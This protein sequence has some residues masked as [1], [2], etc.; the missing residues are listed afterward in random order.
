MHIMVSWWKGEESE[1]TLLRAAGNKLIEEAK[2]LSTQKEE[3]F[4]E[5]LR[6]RGSITIYLVDADDPRPALGDRLLRLFT[7]RQARVLS[8]GKYGA[9]LFL[10][11]S[12]GLGPWTDDNRNH[13]H[14][15]G[16]EFFIRTLSAYS[17]G[18]VIPVPGGDLG[19]S[20]PVARLHRLV[21]GNRE[22]L[23]VAVTLD[24]IAEGIRRLQEVAG[25]ELPRHATHLGAA[26]AELRT[27]IDDARAFTRTLMC[28]HQLGR[29]PQLHAEEAVR[30]EVRWLRG[31][32]GSYELRRCINSLLETAPGGRVTVGGHEWTAEDLGLLQAMLR[33]YEIFRDLAR[34]LASGAFHWAKGLRRLQE[35]KPL[36]VLVIDEI[37]A[38]DRNETDD[39]IARPL[40][41]ALRKK[42]QTIRDAFDGDVTFEYVVHP[43]WSKLQESLAQ[44]IPG[45]ILALG[46]DVEYMP[47]ADDGDRDALAL[48]AAGQ[49]GSE[50]EDKPVPPRLHD[51]HVIL[52]E[53]EYREEYIGPR[54]VRAL[55]SYFDRLDSAHEE[56]PFPKVKTKPRRPPPSI[57]VLTQSVNAD[58]VQKCLNAGA[59]AFV[60]KERILE[61]PTRAT[62]ARILHQESEPRGSR[63]NFRS[64]YQLSHEDRATLQSGASDHLIRGR[65]VDVID[66][67][68]LR[69][70]PKADLHTHIG[71]SIALHTLQALAL[72]TCGH[73]WARRRDN[74]ELGPMLE[75]LTRHLWAIVLLAGWNFR[76]PLDARESVRIRAAVRCMWN[77]SLRIARS[78]APGESGWTYEV[79]VGSEPVDDVFD[80]ILD[81]V[82]KAYPQFTRYEVTSLFVSILTLCE[83]HAGGL[84]GTWPQELW[85]YL[86]LVPDV[87]GRAPSDAPAWPLLD[88]RVKRAESYLRRFAVEGAAAYPPLEERDGTSA[89]PLWMLTYQQVRARIDKVRDVIALQK[90]ATWEQLHAS[91]VRA[92][93]SLIPDATPDAQEAL[94]K[95][96]V[97]SLATLV[98]IPPVPALGERTLKRYLWGTGLLGADH[99]QYPEN[100][101]LA[102]HALVEQAAEENILY[103]ELRCET[104]GYTKAGLS[105][106]DATDLL[107][108]ALDVAVLLGVLQPEIAQT[109]A[110]DER[111]AAPRGVHERWTRMNVLLGAKRH[112]ENATV[113][114]IAELVAYY[115]QRREDDPLLAAGTAPAWWKPAA[116]VGFDLSGKEEKK[117]DDHVGYIQP[118]FKYSAPITIHAGEQQPPE[119]IWEAVYRYGA[120]R[121]GHGLRL[122]ENLRLMDYCIREG[123]CMELCPISNRFT[124][125]FP[126][127]ERAERYQSGW[128]EYYPLRFYLD[129]G[130][131]VCINTDNRQLHGERS[132]LTDEYMAAAELAGGLTAWEV[133]RIVKCGFKHAFIPKDEVALLLTAAEE[134]ILACLDGFL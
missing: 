18:K 68:R 62:R 37:L 102:A 53:V 79:K 28:L 67:A 108:V 56:D 64:L 72:N 33:C 80:T 45:E 9:F 63:W 97:P 13:V 96:Q 4:P 88:D 112:K 76:A 41:E 124:N 65:E 130:L 38:P 69:R 12:R 54:I 24:G 114:E 129:R 74:P 89:A 66:R 50:G 83:A 39:P 59:D 125:G 42:L 78:D 127:V 6:K 10:T 101:L 44:A 111:R 126:A 71:T 55:S 2:W 16:R 48:L 93:D 123:I 109:D 51:Y 113:G 14:L 107:C 103:T 19:H 115:L 117:G 26:E 21:L 32:G 40:R 60:R 131:D 46:L 11:R 85:R 36:R 99:L 70:V 23:P 49:G 90:A 73:A 92:A 86:E 20:Q 133:F 98:T 84:P 29:R 7:E 122:R 43:V 35:N 106:I 132:S 100:L 87:L 22:W 31:F 1:D 27:S 118:L 82:Q 110:A 128:R 75:Q 121:I 8:D 5:N 77:A 57:I 25:K 58:H 119:I 3:R 104:I 47:P 81:G 120:R 91:L 116:V 34:W 105:S 52:V 95:V 134:R 17:L 15:K 61:L 94:S 30:D